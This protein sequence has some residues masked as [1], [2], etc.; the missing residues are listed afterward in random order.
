MGSD[1]LEHGV[2]ADVLND[3]RVKPRGRGQ[4][5]PEQ[6]RIHPKKGAS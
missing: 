4:N 1:E 2:G 3:Q 5:I 6:K